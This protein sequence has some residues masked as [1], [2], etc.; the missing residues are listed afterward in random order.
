M[1]LLWKQIIFKCWVDLLLPFTLNCKLLDL[2][3]RPI[4][5]DQT[6]GEV[7]GAGKDLKNGRKFVATL[8]SHSESGLSAFY[9]GV[10]NINFHIFI[11][12]LRVFKGLIYLT[13]IQRASVG[14][15][16]I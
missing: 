4:S 3:R 6:D 9:S 12:D 13:I 16:L 5:T 10:E 11:F 1:Q 8:Q 2:V 14:Y 7:D 15:K